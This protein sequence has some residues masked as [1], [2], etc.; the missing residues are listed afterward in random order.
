MQVCVSRKPP[1]HLPGQA[2]HLWAGP[3][4]GRTLGTNLV[5]MTEQ[6]INYLMPHRAGPFAMFSYACTKA[7]L[8]QGHVCT[9]FKI[10]LGDLPDAL[11]GSPARH[12][13][14]FGAGGVNCNNELVGCIEFASSS[15]DSS[16]TVAAVDTCADAGA[17]ALDCRVSVPGRTSLQP[18][19]GQ[20]EDKAAWLPPHLQHQCLPLAQSFISFTSNAQPFFML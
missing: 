6:N 1:G 15:D 3:T 10:T 13:S 17:P 7:E 18:D 4:Q 12:T 19:L 5:Q 8:R 11:S 9:G 2:R 20:E 16:T 14:R